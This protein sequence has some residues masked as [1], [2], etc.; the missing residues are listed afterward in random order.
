MIDPIKRFLRSHLRHR[1]NGRGTAALAALLALA[2][3]LPATAQNARIDAQIAFDES[4]AALGRQTGDHVLI[5][6]TGAPLA[7]ADLRGKP[8]VVSLI[9]TSCSTVCPITTGHL[10]DAVIEA[11]RALGPGRFNV[12]T[13]GFDARGDRPAQLQ[14]FANTHRILTVDGWHIASADDETTAAFLEDLG[15]SF[16]A[17][18]GGFDHVM[19]TSI[20]D[21]NGAVYRQVYGETFPLP[22]FMEPMKD[23]VFGTRTRSLAPADLWDRLAF[24]CTTYNP[25]TGAYRFDYGIFGGIAAGALSFLVFGWI[26]ARMIL[27]H[28]R[29]TRQNALHGSKH[30][31]R[32]E[33]G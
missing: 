28:R 26:L 10:R 15:F 2:L 33:A 31:P 32:H 3:A 4:Q 19:Q 11:H 29:A 9:F 30:G 12:L 7:L 8:L 14:A 6:H 20:L 27:A 22:V 1:S 5:D 17:A 13:F 25:L 18:A 24:I 23:L 16:R 21:E